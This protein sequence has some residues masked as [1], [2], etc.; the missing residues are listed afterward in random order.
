MRF[1]KTAG[2][3]VVIAALCIVFVFK[4][5]AGAM[6]QEVTF[7]FSQPV[8]IPGMVL[9]KGTYVF[10][11]IG[12]WVVGTNDIVQV[13]N[14][15]QDTV[16]GTFLTIPKIMDRPAEKPTVTFKEAP[17]GSPRPIDAWWFPGY[18]QGHEFTYSRKPTPAFSAANN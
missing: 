4:T 6:A 13:L 8:A 5:D 17:A 1:W 11:T 16:L 12:R 18:E 7:T 15:D 10:R 2:I 14:E 9:D 3:L